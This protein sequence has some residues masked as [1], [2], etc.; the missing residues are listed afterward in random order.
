MIPIYSQSDGQHCIQQAALFFLQRY[1]AQHAGNDQVLFC[2]AVE[3]LRSTFEL[4]MPLAEKLVSDAY[5]DLKILH[6]R[7][8]LDIS[9][10]IDT[11]AVITDP[12]NGMT[13][14]VPVGAIVG[15]VIEAPDNRRL[16]LV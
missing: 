14:A 1:Q 10:S 4:A 12:A 11:L 9:A 13:W 15:R 2:K 3:Y 7:R 5:G 8:R 6:E 16:R